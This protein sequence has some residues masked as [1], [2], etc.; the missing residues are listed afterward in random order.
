MTRTIKEATIKAFNYSDFA[1]LHA[2]VL[3][4]VMA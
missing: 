4:F 1:A 2:H 3:A